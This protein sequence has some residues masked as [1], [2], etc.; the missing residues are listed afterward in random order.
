MNIIFTD[1]RQL[2]GLTNEPQPASHYIPD[3]YKKISGYITG[4]K[5]PDPDMAGTN[6]TIKKCIPVFDAI[7][8][9]YIITTPCD[10]YVSKKDGKPFYNW[11]GF[12]LIDFHGK[13]Q[14]TGHPNAMGDF[15]APK[16]INPWGIKTPKGWSVLIVQPMHRPSPFTILPAIVDTD[17]YTNPIN[18]PFVLNDP[19]FVGMIPA[20]TPMAQIIP[21]KR[22]KWKMY[23]GGFDEVQKQVNITDR[24]QVKFF[25]R[26]KNFW[27]QK[28][29]Y[30]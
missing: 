17:A 7:T 2:K 28:K 29:E 3:W 8:A 11:S 9:G 19:N 30:K 24:F 18:F 14:F 16:F 23:F 13:E 20:G 1:K 22:D 10:L 27:W 12:D 5:E 4:K 25:D 21:I 15:P 26:Y 6:S